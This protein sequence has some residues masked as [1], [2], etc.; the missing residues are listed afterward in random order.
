MRRASRDANRG[1]RADASA[2]LFQMVSKGRPIRCDSTCKTWET[3]TRLGFLEAVGERRVDPKKAPAS[4][5]LV[6]RMTADAPMGE[7]LELVPKS[8]YDADGVAPAPKRILHPEVRDPI[9]RTSLL[10]SPAE[11]TTAPPATASGP[12]LLER[13]SV[14]RPAAAL[15]SASTP[16]DAPAERGEPPAARARVLNP[17]QVPSWRA[18]SYDLLTGCTVR[19][20]T[21]TIPGEIFDELFRSNGAARTV[22]RRR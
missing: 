6:W 7:Y 18:S 22:R 2:A 21:D 15:A 12:S 9:Y 14:P 17:G 1:L 3:I 4:P 19:D 5:R 13:R 8:A 16:R 20:V 11:G 10:A